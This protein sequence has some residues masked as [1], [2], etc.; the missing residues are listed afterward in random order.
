[1]VCAGMEVRSQLLCYLACRP[2]KMLRTHKRLRLIIGA[3]LIIFILL[4]VWTVLIEPNRLVVKE[5]TIRIGDWPDGVSGLRIAVL[6]DIHA[7]SPFIDQT[8]LHTL[9]AT[10][11]QQHPDL[12]VLL[13]DFVVRDTWHSKP[14]EPEQIAEALKNLQAPLGVYAVLGNHDWWFDGQRVW[15]ALESVGIRV[16]EEEATEVRFRED[17]FWLVGLADAWMRG[18]KSITKTLGNVPSDKAVI[19]L[20]HNPDLFP[21]TPARKSLL[22]LAGHTHGGQVNIPFLGRLVVP[23]EYGQRYAAGYVQEKGNHLFV[24]TGVGTSVL[25]VRFRVPPEVVVLT[26]GR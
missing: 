23:S 16:L 26:V 8:K 24:T 3:I 21:L 25:P 4:G 18:N 1:M 14:M 17:S 22:M 15:R 11:N 2:Y 10:T 12:I 5:T 13:G 19:V 6:A 7:G 9:V 20:T